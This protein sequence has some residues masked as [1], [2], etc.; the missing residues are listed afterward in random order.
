MNINLSKWTISVFTTFTTFSQRSAM[1][2]KLSEAICNNAFHLEI[3]DAF[4]IWS[5]CLP[6]L[7]WR[8]DNTLVVN[9]QYM[10][11]SLD[12]VLLVTVWKL[13]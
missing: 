2:R 12:L 10:F 6:S 3:K 9:T 4:E 1:T 11:I 13:H 8:L 7:I 5:V